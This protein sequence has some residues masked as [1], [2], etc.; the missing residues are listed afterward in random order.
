MGNFTWGIPQLSKWT[1][2]EKEEGNS[3]T[4]LDKTYSVLQGLIKCLLCM[5]GFREVLTIQYCM[6]AMVGREICI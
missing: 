5:E 4:F 6:G 1:L 2:G 3:Q